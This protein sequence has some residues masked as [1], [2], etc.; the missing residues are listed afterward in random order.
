M[1]RWRA[2]VLVAAASA[3]AGLA[4]RAQGAPPQIGVDAYRRAE[5]MQG[6]N[7]L[8]K[9]LNISITP[10][11]LPDGD[12]FWYRRELPGGAARYL[13]VD[14]ATGRKSDAFDQGRLAA[15]ITA[16]SGEAAKSSDLKLADLTF[17][18]AS[19]RRISFSFGKSALTCD[20]AAYR[21]A[22][23]TPPVVDKLAIYAPDGRSAVI[24]RD[25]DLWLRDVATGAERRL[26]QDGEEHFAY[27]KYPDVALLRVLQATSG[28]KLPPYGDQWSPNSRFIVVTRA[29]E[30]T[31]PDYDFLQMLPYDGSRRPNLVTVRAPLSG[32]ANQG[33]LEVS[34]I[35]VANGAA[36]K[37]ATGKE[38]LGS[39]YWW[40]PDSS[41]FLAMQ[42]GDYSRS[43]T[44]F[45]VTTATGALRP[46]LTETSPTFLQISP[47]EYDEP[48]V[49][50][51]PAT[52]EVVWFS[53][54]DGYNHL[55]LVDAA[56]G[57]VKNLI[58]DGPWSV[59][60]I[61]RLDVKARRI[62]FTAVGREAGEDPYF[63]HL[64]VAS[65]DGGE[66]HLVTP[67]D[68]DHVFPG[69]GNPAAEQ[70]LT[71]LGFTPTV[72]TLVSP[73]GR[74]VVDPASTPAQPPV[75]TLRRA[76]GDRPSPGSTRRTPRRRC[77]RAGR[78]RRLSRPRR[79]TANR[80]S[81]ASSS[82]RP[83]S[84]PPSAIR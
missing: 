39:S 14:P 60:N 19:A 43:E 22:A 63:R 48:A 73:S 27:G 57:A 59:Q 3:S 4:A 47:L 42:G 58:T 50:F 13:T 34:I 41:R 67:G 77:Q 65:L 32:E 26:T 36:R 16:A 70:A 24:A 80:M 52:N 53:Q 9:V 8:P 37:L 83:G 21:C 61:I 7:I 28:L 76:D 81:T 20:L 54:R 23:R 15:A 64:Y 11:W 25:N 10:V 46:I 30:R 82:S 74:Y 62:W 29:D 68:A 33:A 5:A 31:I 69:A 49:R 75:F 17:V 51:L 45:E 55:D 2:L 71:A 84:T 56:S 79:R 40:A 12:G 35:D 1:R 78:R 18:D 6:A 38:G 72:M 44:L 66:P